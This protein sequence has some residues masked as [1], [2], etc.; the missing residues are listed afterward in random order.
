[1]M[2]KRYKHLRLVLGDQLNIKHSWFKHK[3][4][5]VLYVLAELKQEQTYVKHHGQKIIAIFTAMEKFANALNKSG[6]HCLHLNLDE[7]AEFESLPQMLTNLFTQ[8]SITTFEYQ[9]PDEFRLL[10]QL[11]DF[12]TICD[13]ATKEFDTEHFLYTTNEIQKNFEQNKHYTMEFFY[14][15]MRKKFHILMDENN[16]PLGGKWNFDKS[17]Q[18]SFK[19]QDLQNIPA[20]LIFSNETA[21]IV[22]RLQRNNIQYFGQTDHC[23]WPTDR[24]ESLKLLDFF[25]NNQL[26]HFGTFQDAMT[27]Q[28]AYSWSLY[29]SRLSFSLNMKMIH[30]LEVIQKVEDTYLQNP[31][32]ISIEQAEGFIRQ[33]LGWREFI[34]AI[35]WS[36]IENK[37]NHNFLNALNTLPDFFWT[38]KTKMN[39]L[40]ESIKQS[41]EYAYAHH[42]QRLMITGNFCLLAGIDPRQVDEWYLG[43]YADAFEW[44]Q[45]PNT[46][47]MSQFADGGLVA[48]KPYACGANYVNK[49]SDYCKNC[50]YDPKEKLGENA[51][52]LNSLYWNFFLQHKNQFEHNPRLKFVYSHIN[53]L[54]TEETNAITEHAHQLITE[55]NNL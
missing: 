50:V 52:P 14:R 2:K 49:M 33:I 38:A 37:N 9:R 39:C 18:N 1:M 36:N 26:Q 32:K 44:V 4:D 25:C 22:K 19:S 35:Y 8:F 53:K 29:H 24:K 47:G 31:N 15:K 13:I 40:S 17:N 3:D 5:E 16:K 34:R 54:S 12:C 27:N 21:E 55:L 42:I 6:Y 43:I 11:R 45:Y 41:L 10:M 7:T 48:T 28:T 20:P 46:R 23:H 51:C 30:P